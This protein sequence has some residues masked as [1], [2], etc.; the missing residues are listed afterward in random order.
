[1]LVNNSMGLV[2]AA[3]HPKDLVLCVAPEWWQATEQ[4]VQDDTQGPHVSLMTVVLAENLHTAVERHCSMRFSQ[5]T[6]TGRHMQAR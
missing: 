4:D 2:G 6:R 1:M 3:Y 5:H